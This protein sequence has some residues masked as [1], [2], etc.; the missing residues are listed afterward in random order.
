MM[1]YGV[2]VPAVPGWPVTVTVCATFQ[3]PVPVG[4]KVT[5][6]GDTIPAV[7]VSLLSAMVTLAVGC[8]FKR[9]VKDAVV[10]GV[11]AHMAVEVTCTP[12]KS[13]LRLVSESAAGAGLYAASAVNTTL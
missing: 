9:M 7:I 11:V 2:I 13:S 3:M 4:V 5:E 1:L 8:E 12:M 6:S 10:P